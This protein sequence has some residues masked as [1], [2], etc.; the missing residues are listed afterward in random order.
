[1]IQQCPFCS[2]NILK[3]VFLDSGSMRAVYNIAPILPGHSMVIP[4]RHI[5]SIFELSENEISELF[6]FA[7][8]TTHV[9]M[10]SFTAD[11]YDWSIQESETAGQTIMHLHLH[12]IPRKKGDL[13]EPG[14][15]YPMLERNRNTWIDSHNRERL[16]DNEIENLLAH[17]RKYI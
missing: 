17:I 2:A 4:R 3:H 7:R 14:D 12:I 15:W 10:K 8:R 16:G 13:K 5:E 1:M 6:S 11:G 9:L